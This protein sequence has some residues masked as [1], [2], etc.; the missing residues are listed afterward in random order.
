MQQRTEDAK[1]EQTAAEE[2]KTKNEESRGRRMPGR[3]EE[4][5]YNIGGK[6]AAKRSEKQTTRDIRILLEATDKEVNKSKYQVA[7][8]ILKAQKSLRH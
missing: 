8:F 6:E 5:K 7:I 2:A 3:G 4:S 1:E